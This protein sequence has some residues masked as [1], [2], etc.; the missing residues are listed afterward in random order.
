MRYAGV[1][2][3]EIIKKIL[4]AENDIVFAITPISYTDNF[5]KR[6]INE[7]ILPIVLVDTPENIFDRLVFSDE[8]DNIYM[9]DK[10]KNQRKDYYLND[11]QEDIKWYGSVFLKMGIKN[12]FV[13]SKDSIEQNVDRLIFEY[14][15]DEL[16]QTAKLNRR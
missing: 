9:D 7:D 11:I 8:N 13:I 2:P 14:H 3:Y 4:S 6:I 10:Y 16:K 12:E 5:K 1:R 15:L